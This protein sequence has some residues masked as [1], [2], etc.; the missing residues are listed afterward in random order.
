MWLVLSATWR[1]CPAEPSQVEQLVGQVREPDDVIETVHM[2]VR[3]RRGT[4]RGRRYVRSRRGP[5]TYLEFTYPPD[6]AG[7]RLLQHDGP[8][9]WEDQHILW[10][11]AIQK[12]WVPSS[13]SEFRWL[14]TNLTYE[15]LLLIE[16]VEGEHALA[17]QT[18]RS[19]V[20]ETRPPVISGY[21]KVRWSLDKATG[22]IS[23]L[24]LYDWGGLA[25]LIEAQP[26]LIVVT[27]PVHG[28]QTRLEV[29]KRRVN[30]GPDELPAATF[31]RAHLTR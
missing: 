1:G 31:T 13:P 6:I 15:D 7:M 11:P 28:T 29:L 2:T 22:A 23:R 27:D 3:T 18:P 14:D 17:G 20:I 12:V 25:K 5:D 9:W 8:N 30:P 24:E 19:W 4:E 21:Q 10:M 26:S 16:A